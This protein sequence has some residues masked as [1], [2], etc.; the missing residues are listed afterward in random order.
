MRLDKLL[1]NLKYGSRRDIK[2][3]CKTGYVKVNGKII[4]EPSIEVCED[5]EILFD[6]KK[7]YY[8]DRVILIMN[9]PKGYVCANKDNYHKTVFELINEPYNR[10]DLKIVGR[11]DIDTEGLIILTNDGDL[12][13]QT[14]SPKSKI[15]KKYY[16]EYKGKMNKEKLENGVTILDGNDNLFTTEKAIIEEIEKNKTF[17]SIAEGKFHQ[18]KRMFEN[19]NCEVIYLKRME[20]GNIKLGD[21]KSGKYKE[22]PKI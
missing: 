2:K 16:V 6:N 15:Y 14:I 4:F 12:L 20:I 11:L 5:D 21:L 19:I 18:V 1:S 9:K 8:K 13:H 3:F 22:I 17:I 7:V 10:Y